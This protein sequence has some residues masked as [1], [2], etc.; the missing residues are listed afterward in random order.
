MNC[1]LKEIRAAGVGLTPA[2]TKV[3]NVTV[4]KKKRP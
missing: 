3:F 1:T 4:A 2:V